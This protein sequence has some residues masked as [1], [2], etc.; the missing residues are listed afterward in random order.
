MR[1]SRLHLGIGL[2]LG[3]THGTMAQTVPVD[4]DAAA[5]YVLSCQKPN[6]AFGPYDLDYTDVAWTYPAVYALKLLDVPVPRADSCFKNGQQAWIEKA[7]WKNGP[8]YWS[9]F[10]KVDLYRLF[11]QSGPNEPGVAVGLPWKL[12]YKPRT[13][14]LELRKYPEGEFFDLASLG[15]LVSSAQTLRSPIANPEVVKAFVTARQAPG[16]ELL[17]NNLP[18][19]EKRAIGLRDSLR[20]GR[21][22]VLRCYVSG[23]L[24]Q[25]T[26]LGMAVVVS[27]SLLIPPPR[28]LPSFYPSATVGPANP[29]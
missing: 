18:G 3:M 22:S 25:K 5:R 15:Q 13:S 27:G 26:S 10:Q 8:W 4:A 2:F 14:Y 6:G 17:K 11:S 21:N 16:G 7:P 19:N 29:G 20:I 24:S 1:G 9:F 12:Y 28:R 23:G